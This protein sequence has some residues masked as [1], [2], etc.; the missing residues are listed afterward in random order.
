MVTL[1][2][3]KSVHGGSTIGM[4]VRVLRHDQALPG[5]VDRS[6]PTT[7]RADT[8]ARLSG[9]TRT[10]RAAFTTDAALAQR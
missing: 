6:N 8:S 9:S 5:V 1:S 2:W 3:V 10:H 7:T 4:Y